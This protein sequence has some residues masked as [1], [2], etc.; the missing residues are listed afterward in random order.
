MLFTWGRLRGIEACSDEGGWGSVAGRRYPHGD[1][2]GWRHHAHRAGN[3][4]GH[5]QLQRCETCEVSGEMTESTRYSVHYANA[6]SNR[7]NRSLTRH[8]YLVVNQW[9]PNDF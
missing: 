7:N 2:E 8:K 6:G 9:F 3:S 5:W 1:G 4:L